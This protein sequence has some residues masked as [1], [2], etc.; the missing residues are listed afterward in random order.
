MKRIVG[1]LFGAVVV[2]SACGGGGSS[3]LSKDEFVSKGNAICKT[4]NDAIDAAGKSVFT[5]S[6]SAP[7]PA[8]FQKFFKDTALPNIKKQIDDIAN[9]KPPKELQAQV[10]TLVKDARAALAKLQDQINTDPNAALN[11]GNDPFADVNKEATALGLGTC[12]AGSG[13]D[14]GSSSS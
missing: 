11:N 5:D 9:L 14:S 2:V 6:N 10:D 1:V 8:T 3:A 12:A 7:D 4:G 13:G